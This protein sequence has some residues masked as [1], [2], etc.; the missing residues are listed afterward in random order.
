MSLE[1]ILEKYSA[2]WFSVL[3]T[4]E[5]ADSEVIKCKEATLPALPHIPLLH[6]VATLNEGG[7]GRNTAA[8]RG[9]VTLRPSKDGMGPRLTPFLPIP[10]I[11]V[12]GRVYH[13]PSDDLCLVGH[14]WLL[15]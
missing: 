8:R 12:D 4:L 15:L 11:L 14:L 6:T 1:N 3:L 7:P 13:H 10:T 2:Q 9:D 5:V